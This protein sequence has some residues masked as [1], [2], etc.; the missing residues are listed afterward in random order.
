GAEAE[1]T[2]LASAELAPA[3]AQIAALPLARIEPGKPLS[4]ASGINPAWEERIET[5]R[6][7]VVVP[8]LGERDALTLEDWRTLEAKLAP[9][10]AWSAAVAA[11][12]L[13]T[14]APERLKEILAGDAAPALR[15]L[16]DSDRAESGT[17]AAIDDVDRLVRYCRNL[18]LLCEDFVN[19][20]PFYK[21][22]S[23]SCRGRGRIA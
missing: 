13:A 8:L 21:I 23:A 3:A 10:I 6:R 11:S 22:G 5:F 19:F 4:L 15:A 2:A 12:P 18:K 16:I 9:F 14:L 20:K 17:A 7:A 1:L